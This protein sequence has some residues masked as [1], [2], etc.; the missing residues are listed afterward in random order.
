MLPLRISPGQSERWSRA[1][2]SAV[3]GF[4][5]RDVESWPLSSLR[6]CEGECL[7]IW[8]DSAMSLFYSDSRCGTPAPRRRAGGF[9]SYTLPP[10]LSTNQ[11]FNSATGHDL[12][13]EQILACD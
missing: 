2:W 5:S 6:E 11:D 3:T 13:T 12:V 1:F 8:R 4:R 10:D 9:D 7:K